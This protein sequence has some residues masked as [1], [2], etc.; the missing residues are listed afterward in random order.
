METFWIR[1]ERERLNSQ[2]LAIPLFGLFPPSYF[3]LLIH[4]VRSSIDSL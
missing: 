2:F 3:K 4:K 1:A